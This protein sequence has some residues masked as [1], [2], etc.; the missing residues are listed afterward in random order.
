MSEC[1]RAPCARNRRDIWSLSNCSKSQFHSH[2]FHNRTPNHLAPLETLNSF[3]VFMQTLNATKIIRV[4]LSENFDVTQTRRYN[5]KSNKRK[6]GLPCF[7]YRWLLNDINMPWYCVFIFIFLFRNNVIRE[8]LDV[9]TTSVV[10]MVFLSQKYH[11]E[12]TWSQLCSKFFFSNYEAPWQRH[13]KDTLQMKIL[14][15]SVSSL[16]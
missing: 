1:Q 12:S 11:S 3:T 16:H 5:T 15:T 10:V 8:Q 6:I 14:R 4:E 7:G 2:L 9:K 13:L